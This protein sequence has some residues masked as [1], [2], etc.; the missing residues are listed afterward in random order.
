MWLSSKDYLRIFKKD[1][2]PTFSI[3]HFTALTYYQSSPN[4]AMLFYLCGYFQSMGGTYFVFWNGIWALQSILTWIMESTT[5]WWEGQMWPWCCLCAHAGQ[6][7]FLD[8]LREDSSS[9]QLKNGEHVLE[10]KLLT[11][12]LKLPQCFDV[13]EYPII[14]EL[15]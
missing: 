11:P 15:L 12:R 14:V 9:T 2:D 8:H 5:D 3:S 6:E 4:F 10:F 13:A 7:K 1:L